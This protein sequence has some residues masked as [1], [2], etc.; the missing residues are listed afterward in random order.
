MPWTRPQVHT[1]EALAH[2]WK[3]A[4]P[5]LS[6]LLKLGKAKLSDMAAEGVKIGKKGKK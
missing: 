5:K 2:G 6:S 4:S 1:F 3:P